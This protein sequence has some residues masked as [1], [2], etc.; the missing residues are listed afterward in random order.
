MLDMVPGQEFVTILIRDDRGYFYNVRFGKILVIVKLNVG[1]VGSRY[2]AQTSHRIRTP[3]QHAPYSP[4]I[5]LFDS[6]ADALSHIVSCFHFY[7]ADAVQA[8]YLPEEAW[9]VPV[10]DYRA[11]AHR[12]GEWIQCVTAAQMCEGLPKAYG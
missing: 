3:L 9:L 4:K 7:Y 11:E 8:G 6:P 12:P 10:R 2:F 1:R 5:D